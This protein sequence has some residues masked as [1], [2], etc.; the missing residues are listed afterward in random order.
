MRPVALALVLLGG[1]SAAAAQDAPS[2]APTR[3]LAPG[4]RYEAGA[5]HR[6]LLGSGYR[7]LWTQPITAEVLDLA[8]FS[9][10]LVAEKKGGGRQTKNLKLEGADGREWKFR[11]VDKDP[12]NVLPT[13]LQETFAASIVQD[14]I[15]ASHPV[16]VLVVDALL[17]AAGIPHV[18]HAIVVL[19]DDPRLGEFR[20]EFA[21]M[22]GTLEEDPRVE[23]PV[24]PGFEGFDRIVD[25]DELDAL[26]DGG[27]AHVDSTGLL[28]ARLF[29]LVVG[30]TDR[31]RNQWDWARDAK[32]GRFVAVPS[33]RDLAFA[34]F[35]GL[36]LNV[37]R[38]DNPHLTRF[39]DRY[40]RAVS[41]EWQAQRVDR[42]YLSDL[43]WA[44]WQPVVAALQAALTDAVIDAAVQR[45]PAAYVRLDGAPMA[46]RLKSRRDRLPQAAR[47]LY[48][49]LAREVD[50]HGTDEP[51]SVQIA[52][53]ADGGVEIALTGASGP[54][55][56]RRFAPGDTD[57]VRVYLKG[58]DDRALSEG[59]GDP[60]VTVRV[61]GG[62]G[63]DVLDDTAGHSR[64][65]DTDGDNRVTK[66][67]GT[68]TSSR[69]FVQATDDQGNPARDWG[70]QTKL[71]PWV[72]ASEDYGLVLGAAVQRSRYGFRKYPYAAR[73]TLRAGYST[74]LGTGGVEYVFDSLRTDDR[75]RF[76]ALARI[77][78]LQLIH[79]YGFGNETTDEAPER[80]FDVKQTQYEFAPSYRLELRQA[81]VSLGPVVRYADTHDSP[82]TLLAR[83]QP[84][85]F[86]RFGQVGARLGVLL[87]RR[88][89]RAGSPIGGM[90]SVQGEVYPPVWNVAETFG[91]VRADGIVYL[92]APLPLEPTL[93]LRAG[94]QKLFG[95]YPFHE[96]ATLGGSE[97]FR[98]QPRQRYWG[99]ASAFGNAELRLLLVKA[100]RS[101][102]PRFGIFGLADVGRVFLEGESSD[103][104]HTAWGG[105]LWMAVA[106][107]KYLA[108]VAVAASEGNV[109]FFVQGGFTF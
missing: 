68:Q 49:L 41:L 105:G 93:A 70:R 99:D 107:P 22:L 19:P 1:V 83:Q 16:G 64:F 77:S 31:H 21:G 81:D 79:Y 78:A 40:P 26:L 10:G 34:K 69:P 29:D 6:L 62:D 44:A 100:D 35:G 39:E 43:D 4:E 76:H 7:D 73:H 94:G 17:D 96:A 90:L 61:V 18:K 60:R 54:Y 59:H 86:N 28:R 30:D 23:P 20:K 25:T 95:P 5:V 80:V 11:S 97:S 98:G 14:Q 27:T 75:T 8:T 101:L 50:V 89:L 12:T 85:G 109:R 32:T 9:G 57:E 91:S 46:S 108:S 67:P 55:F 88:V 103:R 36:L 47:D 37:V 38:Q 58:G 65:Y 66:G 102:V 82:D 106:D 72:R 92:T 74:S 53:Q 63:D 33:D 48:E 13:A 45:L 42:R 51:D 52:R 3:T 56:R 87:D 2:R 84:Y 71:L 15:S 104:W 24:T